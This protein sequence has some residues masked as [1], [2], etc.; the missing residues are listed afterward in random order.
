MIKTLVNKGLYKEALKLI[1]EKIEAE[2][3]NQKLL[4]SKAS[5]LYHLKK[6]D[7]AEKIVSNLYI[8]NKKSGYLLYSM[9]LIALAK[10]DTVKAFHLFEKAYE[11]GN[12]NAIYKIIS[13][14]FIKKGVCN[15][16]NCNDCCCK[17]VILKDF[18]GKTIKNEAAFNNY[19]ENIESNKDWRKKR[20]NKNGEWIF[21]CSNLL[22]NNAC[23]TYSN[24]PQI[25]NDFPT[26][27][28]SL[29]KSCSYY[30]ELIKKPPKFKSKQV[31]MVILD[32]LEAYN[33]NK[34]KK[35]LVKN[36]FS[37]IE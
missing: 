23:K 17:N 32:I 18:D 29:K 34:E 30:F 4:F 31:F 25:C 27:I 16:K 12:D 26:S 35:I 11:Y 14:I 7:D 15:Y 20:E 22:E 2:H 5:I 8:Y 28:L 19:L 13:I 6:Y 10:H 21:E 3:N 33:L 9:A 24:R 36:Q 37:K 1:N